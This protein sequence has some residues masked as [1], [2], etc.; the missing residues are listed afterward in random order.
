MRLAELYWYLLP[1]W[2]LRWIWDCWPIWLAVNG[3]CCYLIG[4]RRGREQE[5]K[6]GFHVMDLLF[7]E[8]SR[9]LGVAKAA[10]IMVRTGTSLRAKF[11]RKVN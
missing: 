11:A 5:R 4:H 2:V 9:E 10:E 6:L 1:M 3:M 7:H 8:F